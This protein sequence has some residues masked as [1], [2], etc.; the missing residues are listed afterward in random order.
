MRNLYLALG[1][2]SNASVEQLA[3]RIKDSTDRPMAETAKAILLNARAKR[4]YDASHKTVE[5]IGHLRSRMYIP[6]SD[7]WKQIGV[8]DYALP[9]K[10][11]DPFVGRGKDVKYEHAD[12]HRQPDADSP[13]R[14]DPSQRTPDKRDGYF[15]AFLIIGIGSYMAY[16]LTVAPAPPKK[17]YYL[18]EK[19]IVQQ[20][21]NTPL[22]KQEDIDFSEFLMKEVP[23][24]KHGTELRGQALSYVAPL[25]IETSSGGM[26]YIKLIPVGT[27]LPALILY[28]HGGQPISVQM[29]VGNFEL[30]YA[31]GNTWFGDKLLFGPST[32]C[33]RAN[34]TLTFKETVNEYEGFTVKLI[35]QVNGNL[36]TETMNPDEF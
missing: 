12:Y 31:F 28:I 32:A 25:T 14:K 6:Q 24:P 8:P 21:S 3:A 18:P 26:Y 20:P 34:A 33:S 2:S 5:I 22:S 23:F 4:T 35:K 16:G 11:V 17:S 10:Y 29:P 36:K 13:T 15:L 1:I 27:K 7:T 19:T 30:R 9:N